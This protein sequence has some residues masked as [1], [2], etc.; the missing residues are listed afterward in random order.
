MR[1]GRHK[2]SICQVNIDQGIWLVDGSAAKE[3]E[4][5]FRDALQILEHIVAASFDKFCWKYLKLSKFIV[6]LYCTV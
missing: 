6:T 2:E 3:Q 1:F 4:K 5:K